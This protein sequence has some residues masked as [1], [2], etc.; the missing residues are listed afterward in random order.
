M[1]PNIV[2]NIV[3]NA[4]ILKACGWINLELRCEYQK[5]EN[6]NK[7]NSII[8]KTIYNS[9]I[10]SYLFSFAVLME[11][12]RIARIDLHFDSKKRILLIV[13]IISFI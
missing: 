4:I 6:I 3:T 5:S 12:T 7:H 1:P 13:Y 9:I 8:C 10:L 11:A 2:V